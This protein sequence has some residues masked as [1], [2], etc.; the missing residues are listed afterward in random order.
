VTAPVWHGSQAETQ[1]L[2]DAIHAACACRWGLMGQRL[3][4]CGA[5]GL[6]HQQRA[7]DG[8]LWARHA[9][10]RWQRGEWEVAA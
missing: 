7:L 8:L 5:H 1:A 6:L 10:E 2:M 4:M 9:R 3:E